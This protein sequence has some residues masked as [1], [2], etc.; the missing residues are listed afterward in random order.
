[1]PYGNQYYRL[2]VNRSHPDLRAHIR[3][4]VKFA[5]TEAK[6]DLIH[7]DNYIEG[8]G[9]EPYSV[10]A[11]RTYLKKKYSDAER[12]QRFGFV[13]MDQIQPPPLLPESLASDPLYRD[14]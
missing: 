3:E 1:V 7:F 4:L 6:I 12:L 5:V 9:Y 11:F 14:F 13:G 10:D 2:W 8:P